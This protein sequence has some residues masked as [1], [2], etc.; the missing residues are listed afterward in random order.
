M[1][2]KFKEY[3]GVT[4]FNAIRIALI[5]PEKILVI[6]W[7]EIEKSRLSITEHL[8]RNLVVFSV[9]VFLVQPK[10]GNVIVENTSE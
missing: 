1:L 7:G 5:D 2:E 9:R 10:F 4:Q 8:S 6:S 3:I